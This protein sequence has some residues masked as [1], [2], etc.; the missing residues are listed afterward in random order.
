NC[1]P[2]QDEAFLMANSL[3]CSANSS[4]NRIM[5][6][7]LGN[8]NI[9]SGIASVTNT[10]QLVGAQNTF[11]TAPFIEGV[12]NQQLGSI[13]APDTNPNPNFNTYPDTYNQTTPEDMGTL[14]NLIYD[15]ANYGSGLM[16]I[17]PDGEITQNECRQ[18]LELTSAND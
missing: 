15:C 1:E 18:M 14:F 6:L 17:F 12:A 3:L 16:S 2:N 10:V 11:L 9:F 4:S 13:A 7:F 8:G 5:E